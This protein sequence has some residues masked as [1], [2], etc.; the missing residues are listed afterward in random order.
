MNEKYI[1]IKDV[2]KDKVLDLPILSKSQ[3][4]AKSSSGKDVW[5]TYWYSMD[6]NLNTKI[7]KKKEYTSLDNEFTEIQVSWGE[8][9][10]CQRAESGRHRRTR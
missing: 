1:D 5:M 4:G 3:S 2:N 7:Y 10:K 8:K 6:D 9:I